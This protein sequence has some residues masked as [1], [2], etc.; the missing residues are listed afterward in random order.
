MT[1]LL[2]YLTLLSYL[3][4]VIPG[5]HSIIPLA[6]LIFFI[7]SG[8]SELQFIAQLLI[9]LWVLVF[10]V[11]IL[12]G[13]T[14]EKRVNP[15]ILFPLASSILFIVT[16]TVFVYYLYTNDNVDWIT[17]SCMPNMILLLNCSFMSWNN[18]LNTGKKQAG[19]MG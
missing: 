19:N 2:F 9:L 10:G 12:T 14:S 16:T 3:F 18:Y 17:F 11:F 8:F 15:T 7:P 13:R 5:P 1:R 6:V 4:I